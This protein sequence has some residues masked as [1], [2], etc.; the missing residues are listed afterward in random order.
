MKIENQILVPT[1]LEKTTYGERAYDIFSRLLKDNIIF[2]GT[3]ID[4]NVANLVVAQLLFLQAENSQ[5]DIQIYINSPGGNAS[6]GMAIYDTM[7]Y[8]KNDVQTIAL[9]LS[10]SMGALLLAGGAKGKRYAL[11]NARILIHQPHVSGAGIEGTAI[12]IKISA[13]EILRSKQL[14][15][16]LLAKHTGQ[17]LKTIERDT[18][19][20]K[21]LTADEAKAYGIVDAVITHRGVRPGKA[22]IEL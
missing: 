10:A 5:K 8:V 9:G 18:D 21:W 3:A 6:S 14:M 7:Q 12:D 19:R 1:V 4:D 16:K 2:V 15:E 17:P 13:Q 20:D 22:R 11:P